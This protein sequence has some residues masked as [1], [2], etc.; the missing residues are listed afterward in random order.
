MYQHLTPHTATLN[1]STLYIL[2]QVILIL[3]LEFLKHSFQ[4]M[5]LSSFRVFST[6]ESKTNP[7]KAPS[8][9]SSKT[10][11]PL[12]CHRALLVCPCA[13][14]LP[15]PSPA[16]IPFLSPNHMPCYF[17]LTVSMLLPGGLCADGPIALFLPRHVS[18]AS[19][20]HFSYTS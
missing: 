14:P 10:M 6:R 19:E 16:F 1:I 17:L 20:M 3:S 9:I 15:F 2:I 4:L 7:F 5:P 12:W 13:I 8:L 11:S 18:M